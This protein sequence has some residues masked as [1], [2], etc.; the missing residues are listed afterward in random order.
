MIEDEAIAI[1]MM[2]EYIGR[3]E[4]LMLLG[5]G[6]ELSEVRLLVEKHIP[7]FI[8]LDLMIPSG[9]SGG[10]HLGKLPSVSTIIVVSGVPLSEYHGVLP[11]G[12]IYE[13]PKPVSFERFSK[14]VDEVLSKRET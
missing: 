12:E 3:R 7:N 6:T 14:C 2:E 9:V 11:E 1:Q 5:I 13:L 10:Y 4:D 8:F